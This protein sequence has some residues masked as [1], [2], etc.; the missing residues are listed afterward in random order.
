MREKIVESET[1]RSET[2]KEYWIEESLSEI[3]F[4]T[5][6]REYYNLGDGAR[7]NISQQSVY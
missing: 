1:E 5:D 2:E 4:Q 7:W 3:E 6:C